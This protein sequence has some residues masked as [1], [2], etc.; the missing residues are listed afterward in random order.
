MFGPNDTNTL[1]QRWPSSVRLGV[2]GVSAQPRYRMTASP[3]PARTQ[4]LPEHSVD[5]TI[6]NEASS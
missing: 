3:H 2:A 4:L 5:A 6:V 1:L